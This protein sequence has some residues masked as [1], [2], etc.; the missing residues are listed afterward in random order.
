MNRIDIVII[1]IQVLVH[2]ETQKYPYY[3]GLDT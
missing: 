2:G 3:K 1:F